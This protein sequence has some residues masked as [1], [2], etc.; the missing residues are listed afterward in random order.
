MQPCNAN[1]V[2]TLPVQSVTANK[3]GYQ[4]YGLGRAPY[5]HRGRLWGVPSCTGQ[6]LLD[7]ARELH[8]RHP[9]PSPALVGSVSFPKMLLDPP[10]T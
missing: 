3:G 4:D 1:L 7:I 6:D 5:P 10:I 2:S 9:F 8:C